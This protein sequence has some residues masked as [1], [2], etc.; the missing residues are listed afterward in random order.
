MP[1][2]TRSMSRRQYVLLYYGVTENY[3][4]VWQPEDSGSKVPWPAKT[5]SF[6]ISERSKLA[7]NIDDFIFILHLQ[8]WNSSTLPT[9]KHRRLVTQQGNEEPFSA[10]LALAP[11]KSWSYF[12]VLHSIRLRSLSTKTV[13]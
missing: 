2:E 6:P 9:I 12:P 10:R 8:H 11:V 4:L 1:N 3:D 5:G 13:P 7:T